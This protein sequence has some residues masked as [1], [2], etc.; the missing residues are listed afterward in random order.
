MMQY[1]LAEEAPFHT[2]YV[3]ALVRDEH[4]KKMAK[5]LGNVIDPLELIEKYGADAVRFTL[6][7]MAAMGPGSKAFRKPG[8]RLSKLRYK[9]LERRPV[10]GT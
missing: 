8:C 2:V 10:C 4:G 7:S 3:H 5:S 1:A 9:N 6:S